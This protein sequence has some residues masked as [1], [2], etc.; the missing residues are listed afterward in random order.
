MDA[1]GLDLTMVVLL[2]HRSPRLQHRRRNLNAH[3]AGVAHGQL[4]SQ[5]LNARQR[6]P[7]LLLQMP[8]KPTPAVTATRV[9][10]AAAAATVAAAATTVAAV[11]MMRALEAAAAASLVVLLLLQAGP[12][13]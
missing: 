8:V 4:L 10:A 11:V 6:L 1:A 3:Q 5:Q 12:A 13:C 9:A 2:L 7:P